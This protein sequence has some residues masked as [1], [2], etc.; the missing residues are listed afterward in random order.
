MKDEFEFATNTFSKQIDALKNQINI[1]K[2][3]RQKDNKTWIELIFNI[4]I[5]IAGI[6]AVVLLARKMMSTPAYTQ[7]SP[8]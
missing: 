8:Y 4:L 2:K 1:E 7:R 3:E 6:V 5:V